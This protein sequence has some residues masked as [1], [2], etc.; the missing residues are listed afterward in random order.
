MKND[1]YKKQN[2]GEYAMYSR[3]GQ[4]WW[5]HNVWMGQNQAYKV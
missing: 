4:I 5:A 3:T 1:C 2:T